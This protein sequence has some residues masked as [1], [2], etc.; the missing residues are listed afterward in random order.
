MISLSKIYYR[1]PDT[2]EGW[3]LEGIDLI[4]QDGEYVLICGASGSGKSTLGYLFNGLVPHFFGGNLEGS[5]SVDGLDIG[6]GRVSSFISKVGLVLQNSDAQLFSSTVQDELAFGLEGLGLSN[7]RIDQ[8]IERVTETLHIGDL[9]GRSPMTLSGGE[10][11]LV[12]MASVLCMN[13]PTL[14]LDEPFAHLDWEGA[15]R[16]RKA[17]CE[18]HRSGKTIVVIEQ[19]VGDFFQD[20]TRCLILSSGRVL[21]DGTPVDA[22]PVLSREQLVPHYPRKVRRECLRSAPVLIAQGLSSEIEK[23]KIIKDI[24]FEVK[25]GETLAI[26]GKNGSGKTTLIKHL[27]ALL[28]PTEGTLNLMGMEVQKKVPSQMAPFVGISFQNPNDQ[29]FKN[30]VRDELLVGLKVLRE[31][32]DQWF[33]ELCN[34]L[35][36]K[37]LLD[38]SP[39]RLSEGQK[40][41]VA[42]AS[43]LV[44][45]PKILV[46]DEPTVGQDGRFLR[47]ISK[48]IM[49]LEGLGFTILIVT[50][51][52]EFA[53]ATSGRWIV[54]HDGRMV[55]DGS[56]DELSHNEQ[57]IRMGAMARREG[58][59]VNHHP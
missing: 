4:I 45:R 20:A 8:E 37:G 57:L 3:V 7:R 47:S 2:P 35:D 33:E 23:S 15:G 52:L 12:A 49:S 10:K 28:R 48:L 1:Y 18:I 24:S 53:L 21:F 55:G 46:L 31:K 56:P 36:L 41:R 13:P 25:E 11:R 9:L 5:A 30:R 19:R 16:V 38:R 32:D 54:L 44:M 27:N 17:L 26:V 39:Y 59:S 6:A 14:I 22:Y 34:L 43:V 51:D 42:L 50:H 29:F 40:K 58:H